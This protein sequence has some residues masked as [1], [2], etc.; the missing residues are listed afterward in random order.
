MISFQPTEE[1]AAFVEVAKGLA[2]DEIRPQA[3]ECEENRQVS[4]GIA[5]KAVELGFASLELPENWGGLQ[6]PLISQAQIWQALSY[7][8][9]GVVQGL[10]GPGDAASLIRL[11]PDNPAL[12]PY[13][14]AGQNGSWP[15]VAYIDA[16]DP[17]APWVSALQVRPDGDGYVLHG[18]SQPVR[19][20]AFADY[21]AVAANDAAGE[22]VVLWLDRESVKWEI[23]GGDYRL[24]LLAA[25]LGR[26]QFNQAKAAGG[27]VV[28][29]GQAAGELIARAHAR[30]RVLQAAKEVGLMEAA[31]DYAT[32]Y[33]AERKAFG[34]VIAQF[35]GVS[36]RIADMVI[37]TRL[38][39]HLVWE[40]ATK[41][42]AD[43]PDAE[44]ASLRALYRAHHALRYVTDAAVQLLG[45]HGFVQEY[46]VEKWMRDAQAQVGLYG[47]EKEM[48]LRRGEQIVNGTSA[49]NETRRKVAL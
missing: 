25:G 21:V 12:Q 35:Q 31:L 19:L 16:T 44:G 45:G 13:K 27:Q 33:T 34:Q 4:P 20:A 46:P 8:D 23:K 18:I 40:A 11:A 6:L 22:P 26:V 9:L 37:E 47:R 36:F 29:R 10:P 43:A 38:A 2:R 3:R 30:M 1:E 28:A 24:G 49:V 32:A 5:A 41:V 14:K 48:L 17:E 42:D 15:T 7:G 39:N